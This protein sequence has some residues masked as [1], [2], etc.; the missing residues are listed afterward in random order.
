MTLGFAAA[1]W[2]DDEPVVMVASDARIS[3]GSQAVLTDV[4]VKTYELGGRCAAV[5]A[6]AARPSMM[7]AEV[8]RSVIAYHN[9]CNPQRRANFLNTVRL[10]AY[11]LRRTASTQEAP[12]QVGV[13]GFLANGTPCL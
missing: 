10:F 11:F 5:A 6:G 13:A 9:Q 12:S 8:C 4:G 1:T 7:A 2:F 3:V